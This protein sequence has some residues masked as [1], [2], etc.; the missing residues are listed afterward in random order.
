VTTV[1]A[2]LYILYSSV[3]YSCFIEETLS[4]YPAIKAGAEEVAGMT[5]E[6]YLQRLTW[7]KEICRIGSL[8]LFDE[9]KKSSFS[10]ISNTIE[11]L[12]LDNAD[13][14]IRRQPYCVLLF[15]APGTGKTGLAMRIAE[16]CI[17]AKY[18]KFCVNDVVILNESD[19]FHSE[20]RT[21][22]KVVIFD[23]IGAEKPQ[24]NQINPFRKVIDFVNN[25]KKTALNPNV[26]LKGN[27]YIQPDLVILTSNMKPQL[28]CQAY[29][30]CPEA[31]YRRISVAI[32][33]I[34]FTECSLCKKTTSERVTVRNGTFRSDL[35]FDFDAS[36][37]DKCPFIENKNGVSYSIQEITLL[38]KLQFLDHID[39]QDAFVASINSL[40]DE[41]TGNKSV[42]ACFYD[43]VIKPRLPRSIVLSDFEES[44]LSWHTRL[45]RKFCIKDLPRCQSIATSQDDFRSLEPHAGEYTLEELRDETTHRKIFLKENFSVENFISLYHLLES[46]QLYRLVDYGFTSHNSNTNGDNHLIAPK[47]AFK[48][49][50][51][52]NRFFIIPVSYYYTLKEL[53][54]QYESL[55]D[56]N[57]LPEPSEEISYV[58]RP[59]KLEGK[60]Y[61]LTEQALSLI[62]Q[63]KEDGANLDLTE[64]D[65]ISSPIYMGEVI[66]FIHHMYDINFEDT[67]LQC[68]PMKEV[69]RNCQRKIPEMGATGILGDTPSSLLVYQ[70]LRRAWH[71]GFQPLAIEYELNGLTVD[72]AFKIN[73]TLVLVEA[74]TQLSP[75]D[76]V[77]RYI[78]DAALDGPVIGVGINYYGYYIY[79]AGDVSSSELISTAQICSAVFRFLQKFGIYLKI[80]FPW[81]KYKIH[82]D[83]YPPPKK[84]CS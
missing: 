69:L 76:Q 3:Y 42:L 54:D 66:K 75:K 51:D 64:V 44:K 39:A 41:P 83:T 11:S 24:I 67:C 80:P 26:E 84:I 33:T 21:N 68:K 48:L 63:W 9:R 49:L 35:R 10:R 28:G 55:I 46:E 31:I 40:F 19:E 73:N 53:E 70:V 65:Y 59:F 15:G 17:R 30:N 4:L 25:I 36:A 77:K 43:D 2:P 32:N 62:H 57:H 18:G 13:G 5:R 56:A 45:G 14:R 8:E 29:L 47:K 78:R 16:S 79:Y 38:L 22:H 81:K 20:F 7:L 12:L 72:G 74:K 1:A 71:F 34:S 82:D 37:A 6:R 23:D 27:V 60:T 58:G 52:Y 61:R 50:T